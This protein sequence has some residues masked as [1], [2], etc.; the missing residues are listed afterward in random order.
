MQPKPR[1]VRRLSSELAHIP[2]ND[3]NSLFYF[4]RR[5]GQIARRS[6]GKLVIARTNPGEAT[7]RLVFCQDGKV[8]LEIGRTVYAELSEELLRQFASQSQSEEPTSQ[9]VYALIADAWRLS[10]CHESVNHFDVVLI[11]NNRQSSF[12]AESKPYFRHH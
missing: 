8:R 7:Q 5:L 9:L 3:E 12:A 6:R 4:S 1:S 2:R 10:H 11:V